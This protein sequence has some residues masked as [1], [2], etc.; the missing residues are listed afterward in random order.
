V[1]IEPGPASSAL[2]RASYAKFIV[3]RTARPADG[4]IDGAD[5]GG[6]AGHSAPRTLSPQWAESTGGV[7]VGSSLSRK[8]HGL[9]TKRLRVLRPEERVGAGPRGRGNPRCGAWARKVLQPAR[10][11]MTWDVRTSGSD[12]TLGNVLIIDDSAKYGR[13]L[14]EALAAEGISAAIATDALHAMLHTREVGPDLIV[15]ET[16]LASFDGIAFVRWVRGQPARCDTRIVV[17]TNDRA[18]FNAALEAGADVCVEKMPSLALTVDMIVRH[19]QKAR[20][21]KPYSARLRVPAE[22]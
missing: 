17:L 10:S 18:R 13:A 15:T 12:T 22:R 3:E 20:W 14:C 16:T 21:H 5:T 4:A 11:G 2:E 1:D 9:E 7:L 8:S 19:L 6:H